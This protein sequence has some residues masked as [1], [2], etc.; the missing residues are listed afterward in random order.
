MDDEFEL[1]QLPLEDS[2]VA[3]MDRGSCI[4]VT[5]ASQPQID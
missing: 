2:P 1:A 4:I 3:T 5:G